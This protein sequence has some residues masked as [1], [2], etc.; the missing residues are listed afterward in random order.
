MITSSSPPG[1][2]ICLPDACGDSSLPA[3]T[4]GTGLPPFPMPCGPG[5]QEHPQKRPFWGQESGRELP[6]LERHVPLPH[7]LPSA[8]SGC[9]PGG[10]PRALP[11]LQSL[12]EQT[13]VQSRGP[14]GR[15]ATRGRPVSNGNTR[16]VH[17]AAYVQRKRAQSEA[18]VGWGGGLFLRRQFWLPKAPLI[19]LRGLG[20]CPCSW[21]QPR[22]LYLLVFAHLSWRTP[23]AVGGPP[24]WG[25]W[26]AARG[27]ELRV[28]EAE[29]GIP[30]P[31][32][33]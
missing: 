15:G 3:H 8:R 27:P 32:R 1:N 13:C 33:L 2:L 14:G 24:S 5:G 26:E 30:A 23:R 28:S 19:P 4:H 6:P 12:R 18:G 22:A 20:H 11:G 7:I 29:E 17:W 16:K 10:R 31:G 21:E 25:L 9:L